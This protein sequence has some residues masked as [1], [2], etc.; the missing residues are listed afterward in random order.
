MRIQVQGLPLNKDFEVNFQIPP[1]TMVDDNPEHPDTVPIFVIPVDCHVTLKKMSPDEVFMKFT[2]KTYVEPICDRCAVSFQA[3]F[4]IESA[5]LCRPITQSSTEEEEED[6]GLVFY[7]KQELFLDKIIREQI[8]LNLP[9]QR[10][11]DQNCK[12]LCSSC[13]QN[14][15][16]E[17]QHECL[18]KPKFLE[19]KA[20]VL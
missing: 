16:D 14:L 5:L 17:E 11:C 13:G 9:M 2:A 10:L 18:K 4:E 19:Y 15:N 3:P 8:F 12:G 7:T 1:S 20:K 6:E